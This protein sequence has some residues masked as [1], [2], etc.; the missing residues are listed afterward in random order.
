MHSHSPLQVVRGAL[1]AATI[2]ASVVLCFPRPPTLPFQTSY[3]PLGQITVQHPTEPL[4]ASAFSLFFSDVL[5]QLSSSNTSLL[6]LPPHSGD[7]A[8]G[9]GHLHRCT[10]PPLFCSLMLRTHINCPSWLLKDC[11]KCHRWESQMTNAFQHR[12]KKKKMRTNVHSGT[13]IWELMKITAKFQKRLLNRQ[14]VSSREKA[15]VIAAPR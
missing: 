4:P 12:T 11:E 14:F 7:L 15:A 9:L 8:S 6:C 2:L 5:V 3:Y 13:Q 10:H 1:D